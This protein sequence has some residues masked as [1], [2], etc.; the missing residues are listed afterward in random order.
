MEINVPLVVCSFSTY[1]RGLEICLQ[2][3]IIAVQSS[4]VSYIL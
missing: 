4:G 2:L 3:C 1:I